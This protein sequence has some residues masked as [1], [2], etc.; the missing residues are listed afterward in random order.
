M[1]SVLYRLLGVR[2]GEWYENAEAETFFR[3]LARLSG[4]V[5]ISDHETLVKLRIRSKTRY[6]K[7]AG[8]Q[9]FRERIPWLENK[10]LRIQLV[11]RA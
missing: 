1:V 6:L 4:K 11:K 8:Y 9:E 10:L 7:Q 5:T 2:V 3:D